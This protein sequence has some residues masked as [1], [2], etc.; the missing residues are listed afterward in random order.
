M[1]SYTGSGSKRRG[2][3]GVYH[4]CVSHDLSLIHEMGTSANADTLARVV[5]LSIKCKNV[6]IRT[7]N[8]VI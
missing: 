5:L 8:G 2:C 7:R 4:S 3:I 6:L 1:C